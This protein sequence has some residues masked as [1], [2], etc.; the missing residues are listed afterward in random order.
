MFFSC[1]GLSKSNSKQLQLAVTGRITLSRQYFHYLK[2]DTGLTGEGEG[3]PLVANDAKT[4]KLLLNW[5]VLEE[6]LT[7]TC[8]RQ[9]VDFPNV[10]ASL[11]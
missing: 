2:K 11:T 5:Q 6:F 1:I 4:S 8:R 10:Q 7:F 9:L 3:L